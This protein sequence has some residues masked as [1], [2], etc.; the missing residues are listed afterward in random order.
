MCLN[1]INRLR[2]ICSITVK[3]QKKM[4]AALP[5]PPPKKD[6]LPNRHSSEPIDIRFMVCEI[7]QKWYLTKLL[8]SN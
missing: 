1:F 4:C 2:T 6:S 8:D 3:S 7:L 5:P